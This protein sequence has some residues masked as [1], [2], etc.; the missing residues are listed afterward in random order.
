MRSWR[1]NVG[2]GAGLLGLLAWAPV[3]LAQA[4]ETP[5]AEQDLAKAVQN[6]VANLISVPLQDNVD[7]GI[8]P[9]NRVRNTLNIQPVVPLPLT[10]DW[11]LITRVI[12]PIAYQPDVAADSGGT[13]GLGDTSATFFVA[14][15]KP[16]ALIWGVGPAL[17]LPTATDDVLGTGK[18][19]IGPS[20]VVL[21]QPEPW[22]VGVLANN[23]WSVFGSEDRASVNQLLL[24]YFI[25]YNL[26]GG[27]YVT[28]APILTANW[29]ADEDKWVVP[30]G[31]GAGKVFKVGG[32]SLNG[33]VSAY[34]NV[35]RPDGGADWQLRLQLAFLFP[36]GSKP[37]Q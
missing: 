1:R 3:S 23:V 22:S 26:P 11:N 12:L 4:P 8:G 33:S 2:V 7:F 16:G 13:F 19:S 25:T 6:P 35:V 17:L 32:Q 24:Q 29:E 21:V 28:S 34:Y 20:A 37:K 36:K 18:W 5:P 30:F 15:A 10:L 14:P 27:W 31:A 9:F